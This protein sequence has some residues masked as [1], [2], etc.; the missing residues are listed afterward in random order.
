MKTDWTGPS[1]S[2]LRRAAPLSI[3]SLLLKELGEEGGRGLLSF[4]GP[5]FL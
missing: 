3:P 2:Q 1:D 5:S 4:I